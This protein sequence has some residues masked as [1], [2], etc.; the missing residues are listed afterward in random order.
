MAAENDTMVVIT[1]RATFYLN[2]GEAK[3]YIIPSDEHLSISSTKPI[4]VTQV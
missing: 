2:A 1:T 3:T 4:L